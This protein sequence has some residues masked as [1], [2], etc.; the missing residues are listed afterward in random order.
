VI[1]LRRR[2]SQDIEE[3][4]AADRRL[5]ARYDDLLARVGT[6]DRALRQAEGEGRGPAETHALVIALDKALTEALLAAEAT[7]RVTIGQAAYPPADGA[8][9][10]VRAAQIARRKARATPAVRAWTDEV[11]RVRT[12]REKHR[13]SFR[14][15]RDLAA[16]S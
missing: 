7:E 16:P 8:A 2:A 14:V 11:D 9:A 10:E 13:L 3:R 5:A 4:L 1:R 15:A 6:V 12:A